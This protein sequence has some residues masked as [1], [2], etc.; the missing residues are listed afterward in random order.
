MRHTSKKGGG[1]ILVLG[2]CGVAI[3][4]AFNIALLVRGHE[5]E[6]LWGVSV[7]VVLIGVCVVARMFL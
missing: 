1:M 7:D 4:I 3:I 6:M 5:D 2:A